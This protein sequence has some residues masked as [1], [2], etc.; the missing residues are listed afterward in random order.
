MINRR[1]NSPEVTIINCYILSTKRKWLASRASYLCWKW[2]A[3]LFCDWEWTLDVTSWHDDK[4]KS[5]YFLHC[6][7]NVTCQMLIL[8]FILL[9][10]QPK[11]S[12]INEVLTDSQMH[13]M[14]SRHL[15]ASD[16]R[17][18]FSVVYDKLC[19]PLLQ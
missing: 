18:Y 3:S 16:D 7:P 6:M 14:M 5:I 17:L 12:K 15:I 8:Y 19:K 1:D 4:I 13:H 9:P 11:L 2:F 10:V